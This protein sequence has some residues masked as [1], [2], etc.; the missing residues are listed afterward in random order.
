VR[1]GA[2]STTPPGSPAPA[3][4]RLLAGP[5]VR[6][7]GMRTEDDGSV[8]ERVTYV[9]VTRGLEDAVLRITTTWRAL[10]QQCCRA[11]SGR[12]RRPAG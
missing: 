2:S 4:S 1:P 7:H 11:T 9:V 5:S 8:V 3:A 12:G 10:P 6:K